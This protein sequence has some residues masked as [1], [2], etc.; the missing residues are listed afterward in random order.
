MLKTLWEL[1]YCTSGG[2]Q[3][4]LHFHNTLEMIFFML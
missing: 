1:G 3:D 4:A 2:I